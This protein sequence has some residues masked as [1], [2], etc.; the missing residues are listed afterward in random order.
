ANATRSSHCHPRVP[1]ADPQPPRRGDGRALP[2]APDRAP[3]RGRLR[4]L[5][6][7]LRHGPADERA[8]LQARP[9]SRALDGA[10]EQTRTDTPGRLAGS[11]LL[12]LDAAARRFAQGAPGRLDDVAV[13]SRP[14]DEPF[15]PG[16]RRVSY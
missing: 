2:R 16:Y 4:P 7:A 6:Q 1:G 14:R 8:L 15:T 5:R 13:P 10:R 3:A 12:S 9:P 11:D